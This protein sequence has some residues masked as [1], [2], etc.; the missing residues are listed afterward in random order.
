MNLKLIVP[1][2]A[3]CLILSAVS[4]QAQ[5][6][7]NMIGNMKNMNVIVAGNIDETITC[8]ITG[9]ASMVGMGIGGK[10]E[11]MP[12][13]MEKNKMGMM[14]DK[15]ENMTGPLTFNVSGK[16]IIVKDIGN[17]TE[18]SLMIG[19]ID[20]M[21]GK[22][23]IFGKMDR[24]GEM[25]E[26]MEN[27]SKMAE[28]IGNM[29]IVTAGNMTG[30]ITC[31]MTRNMENA[32]SIDNMTGRMKY[33]TVP[34]TGDMAGTITCDL[35]EKMVIIKNMGSIDEVAGKIYNIP[36][37]DEKME[38]ITGKMNNMTR[39]TTCN[40]T[41]RM[42]I[43]KNMENMGSIAERIDNRGSIAEKM[44]Y[45]LGMNENEAII[46]DMNNTNKMDEKIDSMEWIV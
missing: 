31:N 27:M 42:I 24:T 16:V 23:V 22:V 35:T 20:N 44:H 21:P 28:K 46:E 36:E 26:R 19:K 7:T 15:M 4:V 32:R 30:T 12:E 37:V 18:K 25:P 41:G 13:A 9:N 10:M 34:M 11:N 40:I 1:L 3:L 8:N 2:L 6:D 39:P 45:L 43:F 17:M 38:N 33:M 29:T 14:T 5:T